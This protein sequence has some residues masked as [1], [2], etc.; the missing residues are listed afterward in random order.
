MEYAGYEFSGEVGFVDTVYMWVQNHQVAPATSAVD[1]AE[2]H[3]ESGRLDF[4]ALGY[5]DDE[6]VK[7]SVFPPADPPAEEAEEA[8]PTEE[9]APAEE[10]T[11]VV[12]E[13]TTDEPS[14]GSNTVLWIV[15]VAVVVVV[16]V[17]YFVTRGKKKEA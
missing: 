8:A 11:E 17:V 12:E 2:C 3:T 14:S 16:V 10:E 5:S 7:L 9:A 1:C 15:I 6:V 13:P 4:A